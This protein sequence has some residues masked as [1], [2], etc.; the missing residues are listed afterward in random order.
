MQTKRT[1]LTCTSKGVNKDEVPLWSKKNG[2][3]SMLPKVI[4]CEDTY[5]PNKTELKEETP[6]I[7]GTELMVD[8][9]IKEPNTWVFYWGAE[10]GGDLD[11]DKPEDPASSYGDESN[12]GLRKTDDKGK[13]SFV[14]N[15]PKLY[16]EEDTLYPRHIHYTVLTD[17]N[18]WTTKIGTYEIICKVPHKLM[19]S[20]VKKKTYLVLNALTK[21]SYDKQHIP[22]SILCDYQALVDLK[23]QKKAT[24][25]KQMIKHNLGEY[26]PVKQSVS[27]SNLKEVPLIVYCGG[28]GCDASSQLIDILYEQ[29]YYNVLEYPGGIKEWFGTELF[30]DADSDEDISESDNSSSSDSSSD[31]E[32][33]SE[34]DE[35]EIIIFEGVEYKHKLDYTNEIATMDDNDMVGVYDG[36]TIVWN[37]P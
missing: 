26:P 25:L 15:C 2:V 32:S 22:N 29:G 28:K 9:Q 16:K 13:A 6:K 34:K 10:P 11:A 1:C 33:E 12:R 5:N 27:M 14:L 20:I 19:K 30:E 23:P 17:D 36:N 4:N 24:V 31:S 8:L 35:E 3:Y 21:E 18:V 7:V 37:S